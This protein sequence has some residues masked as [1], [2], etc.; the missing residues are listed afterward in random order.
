MDM[1]MVLQVL[2]PCMQHGDKADLGTEM[3]W[4][5][6]DH[7]Q[8]LGRRLKQDRIGHFLVLEGDF[9]RWRRQCEDDVEILHR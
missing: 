2:A 8:R 9:S 1:R 4:I 7:A 6:R 5:G 3:L